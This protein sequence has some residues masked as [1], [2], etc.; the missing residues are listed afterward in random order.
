MSLKSMV[1]GLAMGLAAQAYGQSAKHVQQVD[2]IY[3]CEQEAQAQGLVKTYDHAD[4][5]AIRNYINSAE[6][7]GKCGRFPPSANYGFSIL[8]DT[9]HDNI[10]KIRIDEVFWE[11]PKIPEQYWIDAKQAFQLIQSNNKAVKQEPITITNAVP[12]ADLESLEPTCIS[13]IPAVER[14]YNVGSVKWISYVDSADYEDRLVC[15][16]SAVSSVDTG[17]VFIIV[18]AG[19]GNVNIGYAIKD[20]RN[21]FSIRFERLTN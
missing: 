14:K 16:Y 21:T 5:F 18:V 7:Q 6:A 3:F 11:N 19:K 2:S 1:W 8:L 10:V 20:P 13:Q 4:D 9:L 12:K 17:S 15:Y